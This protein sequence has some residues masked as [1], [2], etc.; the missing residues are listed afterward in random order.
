LQPQLYVIWA[1][2]RGDLA[3]VPMYVGIEVAMKVAEALRA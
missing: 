1:P 2:G 3:Y